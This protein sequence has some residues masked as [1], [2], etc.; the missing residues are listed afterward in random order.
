MY[1]FN[2][3]KNSLKYIFNSSRLT[4][5]RNFNQ[6]KS[7]RQFE[8]ESEMKF[9]KFQ[10]EIEALKKD[11]EHKNKQTCLSEINNKLI[12]GI[13][14]SGIA[15]FG[16]LLINKDNK[17][18]TSSKIIESDPM[19]NSYSMDLAVNIDPKH[20]KYY[21]ELHD[22]EI[23][24][25]HIRLSQQTSF[26]DLESKF[27]E[28]VP[29]FEFNYYLVLNPTPEYIKKFNKYDFYKAVK[30]GVI[31]QEQTLIDNIDEVVNFGKL[32][33]VDQ[34]EFTI[35][36]IKKYGFY[37]NIVDFKIDHLTIDEL[38]DLLNE[39]NLSLKIKIANTLFEKYY[40]ELGEHKN[41]K[42]IKLIL[43]NKEYSRPS[44]YYFIGYNNVNSI[45]K[46]IKKG[47]LLEFINI[48]GDE[49]NQQLKNDIKKYFINDLNSL[50]D[51]QVDTYFLNY[52][53]D[54]EKDLGY[55][56]KSG[57]EF[58]DTNIQ[59]IYKFYEKTGQEIPENIKEI[60]NLMDLMDKDFEYISIIFNHLVKNIDK[61][62]YNNLYELNL[63]SDLLN[64]LSINE[65]PCFYISKIK[66]QPYT[67]E[68]STVIRKA[69]HSPVLEYLYKNHY[70]VR[71]FLK[72]K[73]SKCNFDQFLN[74]IKVYYCNYTDTYYK[75]WF[76]EY[77]FPNI[78]PEFGKWLISTDGI[79]IICNKF[80][81]INN[82]D[83]SEKF[84]KI[85]PKD[86]AEKH[87]KFLIQ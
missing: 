43:L 70:I 80:D 62:P 65:K 35:D 59:N 61:N 23:A 25:D 67:F 74:M 87:Y 85:L 40:D 54:F 53:F 7:K 30:Y 71:D 19:P 13:L 55:L 46:E 12:C 39:S 5:S 38:I 72:S 44:L 51:Y 86:I 36:F 34:Q 77:I 31:L 48:K 57:F 69:P 26:T 11:I 79:Q 47:E 1:R 49:I 22:Y 63:E 42:Y 76:Y 82:K 60:F 20:K 83:R 45:F 56:K 28:K 81:L 37:F 2:G 41:N 32:V 15:G 29:I 16:I 3:Y 8:I 33:N 18:T 24:E 50:A 66:E 84:I 27:I 73:E 75:N 10:K 58:K 4:R 9:D 14:F 78:Y 6:N 52:G 64:I 68:I 17:H 21:Y